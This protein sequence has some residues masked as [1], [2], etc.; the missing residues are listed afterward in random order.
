MPETP[1]NI[2]FVP[3][4]KVMLHDNIKETAFPCT[5]LRLTPRQ[6]FAVEGLPEDHPMKKHLFLQSGV[7]EYINLRDKYKV[8]VNGPMPE[9]IEIPAEATPVAKTP[10]P[11]TGKRKKAKAVATPVEEAP[12][13]ETAP[14]EA[15]AETKASE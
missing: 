8:E 7:S 13:T 6:K 14:V 1:A 2:V 12:A 11:A 10:A 4:R 3:G 9:G 5:V 15:V